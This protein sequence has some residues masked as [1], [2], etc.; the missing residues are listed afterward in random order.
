MEIGCEDRRSIELTQNYIQQWAL[1]LVIKPLGP[2]TSVLKYLIKG[3]SSVC[4][5]LLHYFDYICNSKFYP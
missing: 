2:S 4:L 1:V 3:E 5:S